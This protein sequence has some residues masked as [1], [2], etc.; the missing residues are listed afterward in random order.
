MKT[1]CVYL[2]LLPMFLCA[3]DFNLVCGLAELGNFERF[4]DAN[5]KTFKE[6]QHNS[7]STTCVWHCYEQLIS[8]VDDVHKD[9]EKQTELCKVALNFCKDSNTT[10]NRAVLAS[11]ILV[12]EACS[13]IINFTITK[14]ECAKYFKN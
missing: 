10:E 7:E 5:K 3:N 9:K 4:L 6:K 14:D 8:K 11:V 2:C 13:R 12:D 1:L